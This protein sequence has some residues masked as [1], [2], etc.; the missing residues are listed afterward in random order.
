MYE[1]VKETDKVLIFTSN[2]SY[3]QDIEDE[4]K[5][6]EGKKPEVLHEDLEVLLK[7]NPTLS[8]IDIILVAFEQSF[9]SNNAVLKKLLQFLKPNGRIIFRGSVEQLEKLEESFVSRLKLNGF[10]FELSKTVLRKKSVDE[11]EIIFREIYAKKPSYEAGSSVA[12]SFAKEPVSMWKLDEDDDNDNDDNL[13]D[14]SD[15]LDES[16]KAKPT[17]SSLRVCSTTG[18]RKACKDCTCGL[19]EE[20]NGKTDEEQGVK[21]SCGNCYLGDAFRCASCPYLGMAAFKPGEKIIL[22][23]SQL[24]NI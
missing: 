15:L 21:S 5:K 8:S 24:V 6:S 1:F 10:L 2:S 22:D 12:L 4:I 7:T 14:E 20:L 3:F 23:D 19:S 18:K 9:S 17:E 16:E 13:I 11:E